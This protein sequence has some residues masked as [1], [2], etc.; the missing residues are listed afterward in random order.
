MVQKDIFSDRQRIF[1]N[2]SCSFRINRIRRRPLKRIVFESKTILF[3]PSRCLLGTSRHR[4][5]TTRPR[6]TL[7]ASMDKP[8]SDWFAPGQMYTQVIQRWFRTRVKRFRCIHD[9]FQV[10]TTSLLHSNG[11]VRPPAGRRRPFVEKSRKR[12][13]SF[14]ETLAFS[15][16]GSIGQRG[17]PFGARHAGFL[18]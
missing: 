2:L 13:R 11:C 4:F 14:A 16:R 9:A 1:L 3:K 10:T 5:I 18:K 15:E 8:Y 6:L 17:V 7:P 12:W